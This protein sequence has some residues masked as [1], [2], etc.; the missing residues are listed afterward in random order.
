MSQYCP[1]DG[2]E[3]AEGQRCGHCGH[4]LHTVTNHRDKLFTH[5]PYDQAGLVIKEMFG[6]AGMAH[7]VCTARDCLFAITQG[8]GE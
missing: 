3:H 5:C 4:G 2:S 1:V 8:S 7:Y 6:Y